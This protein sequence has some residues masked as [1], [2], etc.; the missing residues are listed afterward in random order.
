MERFCGLG[1][2]VELD[3]VYNSRGRPAMVAGTFGISRSVTSRRI[4]DD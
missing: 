4:L 2:K 3:S 1:D